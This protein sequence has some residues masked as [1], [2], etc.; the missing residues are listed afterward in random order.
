M[1]KVQEQGR[2]WSG[3]ASALSASSSRPRPRGCSPGQVVQALAVTRGREGE[4]RRGTGS[5]GKRRVRQRLSLPRRRRR[6]P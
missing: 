5:A 2:A 3:A 1:E 4:E 6:A